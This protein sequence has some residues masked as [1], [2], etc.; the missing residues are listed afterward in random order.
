MKDYSLLI[1]DWDGTLVDSKGLAIE[2]TQMAARDLDYPV[3]DAE[4]VAQHFGLELEEMLSKL[5]PYGDLD[6][7]AEHFYQHFS[8][9]KLAHNFFSN[10]IETL[11]YLKT[12]GY[13]LAVATN[14]AREKLNQALA[15][16]NTA[17]L[18]SV[19]RS[20]DDGARKPNPAMVLTILEELRVHNK[21][22]LMIG[23][24]IFDMQLAHNAAIDALAACYGHGTR[25]QLAAFNPV[26]FIDNIKE[27]QNIF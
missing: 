14:R 1:F 25:L 2:S 21:D 8:E 19:T 11:I 27:L 22:A 3:P 4:I 18:F 16:T 17:K 13:Q 6:K 26:G 7:L 15:M 5:F 23:D 20:A 12:K 9:E 24:T 10:A